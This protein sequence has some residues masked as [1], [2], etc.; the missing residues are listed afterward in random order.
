[1]SSPRTLTAAEEAAIAPVNI[2]TA[3]T[4]CYSW[5]CIR[6]M[7]VTKI[8]DDVCGECGKDRANGDIALDGRKNPIGRFQDS[9]FVCIWPQGTIGR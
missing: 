1:M 8:N 4:T 2:F 6:C 9:D 7:Q 3:A 5:R